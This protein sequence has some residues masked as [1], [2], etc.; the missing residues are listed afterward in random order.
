MRWQDRVTAG[1]WRDKKAKILAEH[2][3]TKAVSEEEG[4][5]KGPVAGG[6]QRPSWGGGGKPGGGGCSEVT[7][8]SVTRQKDWEAPGHRLPRPWC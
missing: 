7:S 6:C 3:G 2:K 4:T 5:C 1:T 8:R